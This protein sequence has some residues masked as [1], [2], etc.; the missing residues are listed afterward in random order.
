MSALTLYGLALA[1]CL[2]DA[3]RLQGVVRHRERKAR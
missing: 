1:L 3:V 2:G